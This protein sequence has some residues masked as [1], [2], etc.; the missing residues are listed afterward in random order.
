MYIGRTKPTKQIS[1]TVS[2]TKE[3]PTDYS[4]ENRN[5]KRL[6]EKTNLKNSLKIINFSD[7]DCNVA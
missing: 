2:K 4:F 5:E 3:K 6:K 7:W 1:W